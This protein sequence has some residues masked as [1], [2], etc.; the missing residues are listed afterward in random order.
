MK[1]RVFVLDIQ[2]KLEFK[3]TSNLIPNILFAFLMFGFYDIYQSV[4]YK[5]EDCKQS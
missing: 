2:S 4:V 3:A 1:Y 5:M